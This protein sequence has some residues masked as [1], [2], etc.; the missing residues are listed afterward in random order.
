MQLTPR[1]SCWLP[2]HRVR[3]STWL[4]WQVRRCASGRSRRPAL[5]RGGEDDI[6]SDAGRI[7][8][9]LVARA[10]AVDAS[11]RARIGLVAMPRLVDVRD[12]PG[13]PVARD[14]RV[15]LGQRRLRGRRLKGP[16]RR[17]PEA[18]HD[19]DTDRQRFTGPFHRSSPRRA[20]SPR[21][22]ADAITHSPGSPLTGNRRILARALRRTRTPP[23][24]IDDIPAVAVRSSAG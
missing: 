9:V 22:F 6:G 12:M 5:R 20:A 16:C 4:A 3:G 1:V 7:G 21:R 14:T 8:H 2:A 15:V 24:V 18:A 11:G 19:H 23:S 10:V 17:C 13:A